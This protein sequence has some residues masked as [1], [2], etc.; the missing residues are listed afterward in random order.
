GVVLVER[1]AQRSRPSGGLQ[2]GDDS[3]LA[4]VRAHSGHIE[5]TGCVEGTVVVELTR[6]L[7]LGDSGRAGV[8]DQRIGDAEENLIGVLHEEIQVQW[9]GT[10]VQGQRAY[11]A[12]AD[13]V[14]PRRSTGRGGYAVI[15]HIKRPA[16]NV[17]CPIA[18]K[19]T[20]IGCAVPAGIVAIESENIR[21]V[22]RRVVERRV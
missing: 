21:P 18:N 14:S 5:D 1:A 16:G 4:S 20:R 6:I 10:G 11:P 9:I 7:A 17:S 19:L 13:A 22:E 12:T 3:A 2:A 8:G 15:V